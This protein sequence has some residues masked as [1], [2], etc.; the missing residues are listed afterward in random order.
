MND[1]RRTFDPAAVPSAE[2]LFEQKNDVFAQKVRWTIRKLA[3]M[4]ER[5][6]RVLVVTRDDT[7]AR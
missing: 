7:S 4:K 3:E 6:V 1:Q 2:V 5:R